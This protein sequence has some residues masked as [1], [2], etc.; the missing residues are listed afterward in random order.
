M[1]YDLKEN[2]TAGTALIFNAMDAIKNIFKI[3]RTKKKLSEKRLDNLG[4]NSG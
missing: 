1:Q 2:T 3:S 4:E